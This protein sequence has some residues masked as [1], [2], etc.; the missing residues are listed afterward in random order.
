MILGAVVT[1]LFSWV[2]RAMFPST[3]GSSVAGS[4]VG[5]WSYGAVTPALLAEISRILPDEGQV[6]IAGD[7]EDADREIRKH[8]GDMGFHKKAAPEVVLFPASAEQ[9]Q[10]A[11]A[12]AYNARVPVVPR[13]AGSGLEGG[14]I[15]YQGVSH[16][17]HAQTVLDKGSS[18][19]GGVS[20]AHHCATF[21][22]NP[23]WN[24]ARPDAHEKVHA[25]RGR[26]AVPS[27][28]LALQ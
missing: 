24:R 10:A 7:G 3:T 17:T 4:G 9:V 8:S 16:P 18:A 13:G 25:L 22:D 15:P 20:N 19:G 27:E 14:A 23:R 2:Y 28:R 11:V 26:D 1:L 6:F 21:A 5:G 12:A